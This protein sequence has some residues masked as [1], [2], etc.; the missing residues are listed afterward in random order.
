MHA[1]NLY[2]DDLDCDL[3]RFRSLATNPKT[4]VI[5]LQSISEARVAL[6]GEFEKM[7]NN[8]R[9][10]TNQNLDLDFECDHSTYKFL[11]VKNP[12]DFDKIPKELKM[13]KDGTIKEFP[14]YEQIGYDMGKKIPKQKKFFMKE[15]DGPKKP[16][17]VLHL[18]NVGQLNHSKKKQD[19]VNGILKGLKDS[20]ESAEDI[21][22]LNYDGV[23]NDE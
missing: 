17:E 11:D 2:F 20:G 8:V 13:K 14:S 1:K 6:Q 4:E 12:I 19:L 10:P 7:Y 5:D 22:F 23:R 3:D 15:M 9:R 18:V 16:E 21:K